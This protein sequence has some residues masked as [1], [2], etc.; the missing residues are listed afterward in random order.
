MNEKPITLRE[1]ARTLI[2]TSE[3]LKK[4]AEELNRRASEI[5]SAVQTNTIRQNDNRKK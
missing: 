2:A 3:K 5:E 4:E 1:I